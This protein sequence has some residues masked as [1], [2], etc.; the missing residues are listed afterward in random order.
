MTKH[1][2]IV[3]ISPE[4]AALCYRT[5]CGEGE[6]YLGRKFARPEV[7][8]HTFTVTQETFPVEVWGP[9]CNQ[10]DFRV[11]TDL[12]AAS[13]AK[14]AKVGADFAICPDNTIHMVFDLAVEKSPIPWL[15]IA[16]EVASEAKRQ[17]HKCI[18]ILG[19]R[20]L[21]ESSVYPDKL[22]ALDITYKIPEPDDR[23]L[24]DDIINE[25]LLYGRLT[26]KS[27]TYFS[28]VISKL[29]KQGCDAVA[30]ACTEIPL[31]ITQEDSVLPILD[32]TR[33]LARAALKKATE[34]SSQ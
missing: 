20:F 34:S 1:I 8:L 26:S 17:G 28:K 16:E 25:E 31:L 19:S 10:G 21:M 6:N 3:A 14:L 30:L 13:A 5:I 23:K 4:G 33:I 12:M 15:H 29:K 2:G 22:S 24:I 18:G 32:S 11:V 27:R 9:Y 7:T